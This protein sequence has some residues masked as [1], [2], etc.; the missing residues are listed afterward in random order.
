MWSHEIQERM[1]RKLFVISHENEVVGS[2]IVDPSLEKELDSALRIAWDCLNR[3]KEKNGGTV[4][5][6]H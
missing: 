5:E 3:D 2:I 6:V 4:S 1:V